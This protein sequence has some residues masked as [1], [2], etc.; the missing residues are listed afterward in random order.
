MV[1]NLALV[2]CRSSFLDN[3][4]IYP[5]LGLLY[6]DAVIEQKAPQ[7]KVS[8]ID[9]YDLTKNP[10]EGFDAVGISIMTPQREESRRLL[11]HLKEKGIVAIAGG[12]H[13]LHYFEEMKSEPWDFIV[14]KDGE[15]TLVDILNG[16]DVPRESLDSISARELQTM[17]RPNR[18]KWA[19]FLKG[20]SYELKGQTATTMMTGRGCP[21][22]CFESGVIVV[23]SDSKN[24]KIKN[25]KI[26]DKLLAFDKGK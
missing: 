17:P 20:Y 1:S 11:T 21:E 6:L 26:G 16:V 23:K 13:A 15:R 9:E 25:I 22:Q 14:R 3:D 10:F 19:E 12:P 8:L 7:V 2:S 18:L 24:D 5:P 4:R